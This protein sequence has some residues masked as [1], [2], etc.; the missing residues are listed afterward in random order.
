MK[1]AAAMSQEVDAADAVAA[2]M[3][4]VKEQLGAAEADLTLV[5][6]SHDHRRAFPE[7]AAWIQAELPSK[8]LLGATAEAVVGGEREIEQGPVV[9]IWSAVRPQ[10][11]FVP[12]T[13]EFERTPDGV[14]STGIPE[15][16]VDLVDRMRAILL[17]AE[18]YSSAP[19][20]LLERFGDD[21]PGVPIIG[22]MASGAS[23][24]GENRLFF[25]R[26][27]YQ[28]GAIG[29]AILDGPPIRTVVSQGCRPL[30]NPYVI[31]KAERNVALE[32]GGKPALQRAQEVY[33]AASAADRQLLEQGLHL[34]VAMS[35]YRDKYGQGDFL[36]A[37]VLGADRSSGAIAV[38]HQLRTGQTVQFHV[39]DADSADADLRQLLQ[40]L[41]DNVSA[42]LV[43]SLLFSCNGRGTRMFPVNHHDA[44][45]IQQLLGPTPLAGMF[46][47]GEF[48][49]V[50]GQNYI[51]GFTA[52]IAIFE[53]ENG[54]D[55]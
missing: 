11:E 40:G 10:S 36:V 2:T 35:E 25:G 39:R 12:F 17:I 46:A 3:R 13:I 4:Q 5:F 19:P 52:S 44:A 16:L 54:S 21:C 43:G 30:G 8:V 23:V 7:I 22:G 15:E 55:H 53:G 14:I 18:P 47:N 50:S 33:E 38:G 29:V 26:S 49:P 32:L 31:T 45:T 37:N 34:G 28:E 51:H 24:A 48:G 27:M 20:A 41:R 1:C 42:S 6:I 9:S